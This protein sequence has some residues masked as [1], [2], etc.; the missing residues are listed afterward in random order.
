MEIIF[1]QNNNG[2]SPVETYIKDLDI[3]TQKKILWTLEIVEKFG[4]RVGNNYFEKLKGFNLYEIKVNF[5]KKWHRMLCRV[6][7]NKCYLLHGFSKKS[8][9]TPNREIGTALNRAKLIS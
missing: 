7:E 3:K 5:N 4:A 6:K 2:E 1:W 8:N 9:K